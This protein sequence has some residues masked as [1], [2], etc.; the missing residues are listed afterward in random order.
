[1]QTQWLAWNYKQ[2][3]VVATLKLAEPTENIVA[4]QRFLPTGPIALLP[5]SFNSNLFF[6][7]NKFCFS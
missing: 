5:V 4:W 6:F 1:M 7:F 3:G 2:F